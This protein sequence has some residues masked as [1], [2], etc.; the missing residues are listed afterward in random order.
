MHQSHSFLKQE[1]VQI[2]VELESV[3]L[4]KNRNTDI[5]VIASL[6]LKFFAM[7]QSKMS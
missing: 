7:A 5:Q 6:G 1:N 4:I 2:H 3:T